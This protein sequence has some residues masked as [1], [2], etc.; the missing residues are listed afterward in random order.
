MNQVHIAKDALCFAAGAF[1]A[2]VAQAFGGWSGAMTTLVIC[3]I[4]DYATGL[5]V[6]GVFHKSRKTE[7]GTLESRAGWKGL[8]RKGIS[9]LVVLIAARLDLLLGT[10]IIRDTV[11]IGF[12]A[13][14]IISI[15]ENAGLI[16]IPIPKVVVNAIHV[17]KD[18]ESRGADA[19]DK[20]R[21]PPDDPDRED[22]E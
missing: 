9:L 10:T 15:T 2:F 3:M 14:E 18:E 11:I 6:A 12:I 8:V 4:I 21:T 1:G 7:D 20:M 19:V 17:L 5:I 22:K 16:G 13:N